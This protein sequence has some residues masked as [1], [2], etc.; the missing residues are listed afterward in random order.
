MISKIMIKIV[1][2]YVMPLGC[3]LSVAAC[4]A[5][6]GADAVTAEAV[7]QHYP[8]LVHALYTDAHAR[9]Q[10]LETAVKAFVAAPS[11]AGLES[12]RAA[13]KAARIPYGQTEAFRFADGP[14]DAEGGP[15]GRLNAWPL[16]EAYIDYVATATE[17]GIINDRAIE[18]TAARLSALNE[19]AEGDVLGMGGAFD[20]EKAVSTGYHAIEFL[21]W[22]Q[23]L[24]AEGPGQRP[25]TDFLTGAG[26]SAPN[27]D[28]RGQYLRVVTELLVSDLASLVAAWAPD[29]DNYRA[30]FLA[31]DPD[32]ALKKLLAP[33]GILAKGEL[34]GERM[35]V[36]LDTRDQEDEHSCFS[37]NTHVDIQMNAKGIE[38]V[39]LGRY[40]EHSGASLQALLREKDA[41][42]EAS[43]TAK[44]TSVMA[45][46]DAIPAP[47]DQAISAPESAGYA[48]IS[49][50]VDALFDLGDLVAEAGPALGLGAISVALP[51]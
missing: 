10:E 14:I 44:L 3:L 20:E 45:S 23:D 35:D 16:D 6:D 12:A 19:G 28:R 51:E 7:V 36:A 31:M 18:L 32:E 29:A 11:A 21:L 43:L 26:A 41:A 42:L 34:G 50:A 17:S 22:G 49:A 9:A 40:G 25:Y 33:L 2:S 30:T 48:A 24:S 8:V 13:W 5:D 1:K 39:Y 27:G 38:N 47:F 15:E 46:V 4:G 37:D